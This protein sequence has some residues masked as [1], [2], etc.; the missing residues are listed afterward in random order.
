MFRKKFKPHEVGISPHRNTF[1]EVPNLSLFLIII[2]YFHTMSSNLSYL[3]DLKTRC[4]LLITFCLEQSLDHIFLPL[5]DYLIT[6]FKAHDQ[7]SNPFIKVWQSNKFFPVNYFPSKKIVKIQWHKSSNINSAIIYFSW[8]CPLDLMEHHF[9]HVTQHWDTT[10]Q[11]CS[12]N[13][14]WNLLLRSRFSSKLRETIARVIV[15]LRS[16]I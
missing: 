11:N 7:C 16:D 12:S 5:H 6:L 3:K 9:W 10:E 13:R 1:T 15:K 14:K 8:L 2:H 4:S